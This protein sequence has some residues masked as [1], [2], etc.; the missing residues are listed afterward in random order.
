MQ[1]VLDQ[2]KIDAIMD[3]SVDKQEGTGIALVDCMNWK[4]TFTAFEERTVRSDGHCLPRKIVKLR[5]VP[6]CLWIF[7]FLRSKNL[8]GDT[9]LLRMH[10]S[11]DDVM[12]TA[13]CRITFGLVTIAEGTMKELGQKAE[14]ALAYDEFSAALSD[15]IVVDNVLYDFISRSSTIVSEHIVMLDQSYDDM[16]TADRQMKSCYVVKEPLSFS[17]TKSTMVVEKKLMGVD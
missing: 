6:D 7:H 3:S 13:K 15:K 1:F 14:R 16:K 4:E 11:P 9:T 8:F 17:T 12:T 2:M 10:V 5:N